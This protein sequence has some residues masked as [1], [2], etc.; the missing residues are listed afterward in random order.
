MV[1]Q[2]YLLPYG[3]P[4]P[5]TSLRSF[6][7]G[8]NTLSGFGMNT[9]PLIPPRRV[10]LDIMNVTQ[11]ACKTPESVKIKSSLGRPLAPSTD[12]RATDTAECETL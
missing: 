2:T 8:Y 10:S 9:A 11:H 12:A 1:E 7:G 6:G 5:C 3:R 4:F